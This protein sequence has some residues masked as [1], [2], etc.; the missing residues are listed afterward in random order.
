MEDSVGVS[1]VTLLI[2]EHYSLLTRCLS[3]FMLLA[4]WLFISIYK[5]HSD[6]LFCKTI[7]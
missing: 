5:A 2:R 6:A 4:Y 3:A 7:F 1:V